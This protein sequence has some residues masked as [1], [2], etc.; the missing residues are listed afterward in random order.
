MASTRGRLR[1]TCLAARSSPVRAG[2]TPDERRASRSR[3][4]APVLPEL[5]EWPFDPVAVGDRP[6]EGDA[7]NEAQ[8]ARSTERRCHGPLL[9]AI[10]LRYRRPLP[11]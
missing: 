3:H 11:P 9:Q 2:A 6:R 10:V 8:E 4:V 1:R 7:P 5:F